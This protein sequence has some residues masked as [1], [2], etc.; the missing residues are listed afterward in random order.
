MDLRGQLMTPRQWYSAPPI[1][2]RPSPPIFLPPVARIFREAYAAKWGVVQPCPARSP[3]PGASALMSWPQGAGGRLRRGPP[4][5]RSVPSGPRGCEWRRGANTRGRIPQHARHRRGWCAQRGG[6]EYQAL[7]PA[8]PP[9]PS[10]TRTDKCPPDC[11]RPSG[12]TLLLEVRRTSHGGRDDRWALSWWSFPSAACPRCQCWYRRMLRGRLHRAR[13][14]D[15]DGIQTETAFSHCEPIAAWQ[16][17]GV[18]TKMVLDVPTGSK[19]DA[20]VSEL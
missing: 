15:W 9:L 5:V 17:R 8:H 14:P 1:P 4:S 16:S 13:H 18:R 3:N 20:C 19:S 6:P 7:R 11:G 12:R 2:G 10:P